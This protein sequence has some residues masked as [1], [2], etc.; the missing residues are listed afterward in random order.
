V[1]KAPVRA[2]IQHLQVSATVGLIVLLLF[3]IPP[4]AAGVADVVA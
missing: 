3:L 1:A 4:R 2:Q